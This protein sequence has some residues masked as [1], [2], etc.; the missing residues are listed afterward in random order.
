MESPP[1]PPSFAWWGGRDFSVKNFEEIFNGEAEIRTQGPHESDNGFQD[2]RFQPLS[3]LSESFLKFLL[4]K[5]EDFF[6]SAF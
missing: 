5:L 2:R 4:G 3:H 6:K 1:R